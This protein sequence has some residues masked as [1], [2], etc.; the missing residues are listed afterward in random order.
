MKMRSPNMAQTKPYTS[1]IT[2]MRQ[3]M[4]ATIVA[5]QPDQSYRQEPWQLALAHQKIIFN[6]A[7]KFSTYEVPVE[8][9]IQVGLIA[10]H[11]AAQT[12][13][14]TRGPLA[15]RIGKLVMQDV[16]AYIQQEH[17]SIPPNSLDEP[18]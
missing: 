8:D 3:E 11:R 18:L 7:R 10:A 16:W 9:L 1:T 13:D 17:K 14:P 5:T 15:A 12:W 6:I 4:A 2:M